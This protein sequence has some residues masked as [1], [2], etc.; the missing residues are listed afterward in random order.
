MVNV[1]YYYG[2]V[3]EKDHKEMTTNVLAKGSNIIID[4]LNA[5][6]YELEDWIRLTGLDGNIDVAKVTVVDTI[7]NQITID[8][9]VLD[10]EIDTLIEILD[11]PTLIRNFIIIESAI[12]GVVNVSG[13]T[14]KFNSSYNLGSLSA[15]KGIPLTHW[16]EVYRQLEKERTRLESKINGVL[17]I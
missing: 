16:A 7:N 5:N 6:D 17:M 8:K 11:I 3:E 9:I 12:N 4:V 1:E 15:V 10:H 2:W 13:A 14:F